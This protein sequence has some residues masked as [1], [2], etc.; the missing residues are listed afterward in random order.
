MASGLSDSG[1]LEDFFAGGRRAADV[2]A[3]L[4]GRGSG[5]GAAACA[6]GFDVAP[7]ACAGGGGGSEFMMLTGGIE[8]AE[9][10]LTFAPG[11]VT[12]PDVPDGAVDASGRVR[13]G[14][15]TE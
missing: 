6:G 11:G 8:A 12:A 10:K 5:V 14:Q 4:V 15:F 9:G 2:G 3:V 1:A 7:G 13:V